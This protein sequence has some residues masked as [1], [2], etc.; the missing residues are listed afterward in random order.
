MKKKRLKIRHLGV[1]LFLLF[2]LWTGANGS[3]KTLIVTGQNTHDWRTSSQILK[4]ILE[5]SGLFDVQMAVS[6]EKGGSMGNYAPKFSD[7]SLVVLDYNGDR[8][9]RRTEKSMVS[10]VESGGG[11]VVYHS[12]SF[13]FP[14]WFEYR[15]II[16]LGGGQT[17]E[18]AGSYLFWR[19]GG[20]VREK[21]PGVSGYKGAAHEFVVVNRD[22]EHPITS[23][24]PL[25]WMHAE[26]VL[27]GLL[28][29]SSNQIHVLATAFNDVERGGTGRHEPVLFTNRYVKGR[30]FHT[31]LGFVSGEGPFPAM[32]CVGFIVT[33]LRGAEWAASGK[34]TQAVPGDFPEVTREFPSPGD[35]RLWPGYRPPSLDSIL[36]ELSV[37]EYGQKEDV[38]F[39]LREYILAHKIN[40]RAREQ[41]EESLLL[42]LESEATLDGRMEVCRS[43]RQIGSDKS[44]A[45][46]EKMLFDEKT[47]DMARYALE[48]IP[49]TQADKALLRGL[50]N[51]TKKNVIGIVSSMGQ[52]G[53]EVAVPELGQLLSNPDSAVAAAAATALGWIGGHEAAEVLLKVFLE[54]QGEVRF[55]AAASLLRCAETLQTSGQSR[56]AEE[57]YKHLMEF[58]SSQPIRQAALKGLLKTDNE[59]AQPLLLDVLRGDDP[60]LHTVAIGQIS[61]VFEDSDIQAVLDLMPQLPGKAQMAL[62]PVLSFYPSPLVLSAVLDKTDSE[63]VGVRC[64]ALDA[65][66]NFGDASL[67]P[68]LAERAA[69]TKGLEKQAAQSSLWTITGPGVNQAIL[70]ELVKASD[71]SLKKELIRC[72]GERRLEK[73]KNI[74][75]ELVFFKEASIRTSALQSLERMVTAADL[76]RLL[77]LLSVLEEDSN[78]AA[79][80]QTVASSLSTAVNRIGLAPL[81]IEK[82]RTLENEQERSDLLRV[83]GVIGENRTLPLLRSALKNQRSPEY[84]SAVRALTE[85]PD[86]T[87]R[88]DLLAIAQQSEDNSLRVL[89][90]RA[91]IQMVGNERYRS[92]M[93]AVE[94]L[95]K[96]LDVAERAE[97][98]IQ[99]LA[100][101]PRYPCAQALKLAESMLG[102][103]SVHNEAALAIKKIL[104]E[105]FRMP[106]SFRKF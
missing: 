82:Y 59:G 46:L 95:K 43:L 23:G 22:S 104:T 80:R 90:L 60:D 8:W 62:L 81:L 88:D 39:S 99:I 13:A 25:K 75:F 20:I 64:S 5:G 2:F 73:A 74:L 70:L 9:S 103:E 77:D 24:L 106:V 65:L 76:P 63:H 47:S 12:S 50:K 92:P 93:G 86:I 33:L 41:C 102:D 7:Y 49:G 38:L 19:D 105:F 54:G 15:E 30:I 48:K 96:G 4:E 97:E 31:T 42:Y 1:W 67:V 61:A 85:W 84:S 94:A 91:Y 100:L 28:R 16:G 6:P 55:Q 10:Y 72:V 40:P 11:I 79:L 18:T 3:I 27:F 68:F 101:L 57:F 53:L 34:V 69:Q 36:E 56:Q 32:E 26:D 71:V 14:N 35:V 44:V 52:R 51:N 87:P 89:S 78:K 83:L 37:Y 58:H 21:N 45:V 17:A 98:K 66:A 29:G